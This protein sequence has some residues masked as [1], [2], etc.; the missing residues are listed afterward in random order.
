MGRTDARRVGARLANDYG[1]TA[2]H[3]ARASIARTATG[4]AVEAN[5][6]R[7]LTFSGAA[8]AVVP[9]DGEPAG[10]AL[11]FGDCVSDGDG[12]TVDADRRYPDRLADHLT[13]LRRPAP[14]LDAGEPPS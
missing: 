2:R 3:I 6:A 14:V 7:P 11:A 4:G 8:R 1:I 9:A 5:S 13:A 12:S 10:D